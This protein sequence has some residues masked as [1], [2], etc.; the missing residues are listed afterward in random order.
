MQ[1]VNSLPSTPGLVRYNSIN[2]LG[3]TIQNNFLLDEH[4]AEVCS[5]A[6]QAFYAIKVLKNAGLRES[7]LLQVF[8]ALVISRLTYA[9]SAWMGFASQGNRD[10]LHAVLD[11]TVRWGFYPVCASSFQHI[12][13]E[14]DTSLFN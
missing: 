8:H 11:K 5:S 14:R 12:F 9:S 10:R 7:C 2:I 3:V 4:V 6:A 13:Y 1:F